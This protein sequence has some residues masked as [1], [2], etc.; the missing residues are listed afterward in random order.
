M[1]GFHMNHFELT[2]IPDEKS[3]SVTPSDRKDHY[4]LIII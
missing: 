3:G 1:S 2:T 4:I